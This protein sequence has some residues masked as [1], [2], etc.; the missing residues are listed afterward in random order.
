MTSLTYGSGSLGYTY[1][2]LARITK[3]TLTPALTDIDTTY[4][5]LAGGQRTNSTTGLIQK[6]T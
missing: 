1:D 2:R 4:T 3:R 6:I 5:Y